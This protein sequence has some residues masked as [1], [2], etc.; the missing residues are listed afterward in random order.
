MI[1]DI[2]TMEHLRMER[3]SDMGNVCGQMEI[4]SR[5][6]GTAEALMD[7][8]F[9][10]IRTVTSTLVL[11]KTQRDTELECFISIK[12]SVDGSLENFKTEPP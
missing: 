1:L 9:I 10:I 6:Y 8:E 5:A 11:G 3:N 4:H 12:A 7:L 2:T